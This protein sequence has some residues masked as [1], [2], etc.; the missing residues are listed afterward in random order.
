MSRRRASAAAEASPAEGSFAANRRRQAAMAKAAGAMDGWR[1]AQEVL[2]EV[3]AVPTRFLQYDVATG[4]GGHPISRIALL[5]GPSGHGKSKFALGLGGS[6]LARDHFFGLLDAERTTPASWTR[7]LLG[8]LA[9]SPAFM[10]LPASSFEKAVE[11][12]R[13][14]CG[15]VAKARA[16]VGEDLTAL[17]VVDSIR[18]LQPAQ[19]MALALKAAKVDDEEKKQRGRRGGKKGIDGSG[20]RSGQIKA[21]LNSIWVDELVP[22]L[23]DTRV[24]L[25][26]VAREYDDEDAGF[27]DEGVKVGGGKNLVFTASLR[28]RVTSR[29]AFEGEEGKKRSVGECHTVAIHK[30]KVSGKKEPVV[31]AN[32]YTSNGDERP[33]GFWPEWDALE[34]AEECGVVERRGSWYQFRGRRIGNGLAGAR[35]R[36]HDEPA[37]LGEIDLAVRETTRR[38]PA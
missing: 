32:F 8:P 38:R 11:G 37:L 25:V 2:R 3:E 17:A 22:L 29:F 34:I 4:V 35:K 12:M 5:H 30:T 7:E 18:A 26:L 15:A 19:M 20:G 16:S 28:L 1:P 23:A 36:L 27:F 31:Y 13:T 10:A 24:G 6:F 14:F 21:H 9:D 33:E